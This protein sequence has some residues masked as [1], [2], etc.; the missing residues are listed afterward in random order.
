MPVGETAETRVSGT[1][2]R[3][4]SEADDAAAAVVVAYNSARWLP[5]CLSALLA[6]RPAPEVIVVDNASA[7]GSAELAAQRFPTVRLI[8]SAVNL[9]F[10]GGANLG[11]RAS[12]AGVAVILNPDVEVTPDAIAHLVDALQADPAA[13]AAGG[14]LLYP[15]GK[16]IQHA[17]GTLSYPLALAEHP[18]R[19]EED[20]GQYDAS[21]EVEYVTGALFAVRRSVLAEI[22]AF[23]EGFYPAYFEETDLC[24]RAR[25]AGYRVLYVPAAVAIH[26]ESVTVGRE[27]AASYRFYHR[28]RLRYVLKHYTDDQLWRDFLPAE[29]ERLAG[30]AR[31][32]VAALRDACADNL[33]V[34]A[35]RPDF[36]ANPAAAAPLRASSRRREI[37]RV[38]AGRAEAILA[39]R[40]MPAYLPPE[41]TAGLTARGQLVEPSFRSAA[42]LI[43]PLIIRVRRLWN[44]MSTKWYV[45]PIVDQQSAFNALVVEALR[46]VELSLQA[47]EA[48]TAAAEEQGIRLAADLARIEQRLA[49][50]EERLAVLEQAVQAP[51]DAASAPPR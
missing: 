1:D 42:P 46:A 21:R 14:K 37:L 7:D 30:L 8:R 20:R 27:T 40:E 28:N 24:R 10:A 4:P 35:G 33:A 45:R 5:A 13:A 38:L 6:S 11:L 12:R 9:G 43:G 22:G 49:Q 32:E 26:H 41:L 39:E 47:V 44:W 3:R 15:D 50:L 18:G 48:S 34:L 36:L 29:L 19:G 17:G 16:T 2:G 25:Q 31:A 23:D 51:P